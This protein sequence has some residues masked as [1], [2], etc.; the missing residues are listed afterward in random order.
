MIYC[1]ICQ[2]QLSI[3]YLGKLPIQFLLL[4]RYPIRDMKFLFP[5]N[6]S[7][8]KMRHILKLF[9]YSLVVVQTIIY[10]ATSAQ[11]Y[12]RPWRAKRQR[13]S[14][15][16]RFKD[17]RTVC[18]AIQVIFCLLIHSQDRLGSSAGRPWATGQSGSSKSAQQQQ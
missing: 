12:H 13:K 7:D 14:I 8:F 1:N 17:P 3:V 5:S 11:R 2:Q 15:L 10:S 9:V 18:C 4:I 16:T 6:F